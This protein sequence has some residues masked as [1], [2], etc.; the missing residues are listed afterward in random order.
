MYL[1]MMQKQGIQI[2]S[3][4][5]LIPAKLC[6]VLHTT[7]KSRIV[8]IIKINVWLCLAELKLMTV[9]FFY[10]YKSTMFAIIV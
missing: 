7:V 9:S 10:L 3:S 2:L 6:K 1:E 8:K 4:V 5:K